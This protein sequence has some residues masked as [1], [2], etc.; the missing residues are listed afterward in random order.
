VTTI[1]YQIYTQL[2]YKEQR[3][4]NGRGTTVE[5]VK[6]DKKLSADKG[7]FDWRLSMATLAEDGDYSNFSSID[8]TQVMLQGSEVK[9]DITASTGKRET[10]RVNNKVSLTPLKYIAFSGEDAVSCHLPNTDSATMFNVMS[11]STY[12]R[13]QVE[14]IKSNDLEKTATEC[15]LLVIFVVNDGLSISLNGDTCQLSTHHLL[16]VNVERTPLSISAE[17]SPTPSDLIL[18]KFFQY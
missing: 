7:D 10:Q 2:D 14:V 9:L 18:V 8:R 5:L 11:D 12:G 1:N 15:D 16:Q 6:Q 4:K 3:W 13:H 17:Q